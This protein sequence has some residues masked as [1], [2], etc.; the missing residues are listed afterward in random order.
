MSSSLIAINCKILSL[1]TKK[2]NTKIY[3]I[4]VYIDLSFWFVLFPGY[5][6]IVLVLVTILVYFENRQDNDE[7]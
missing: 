1:D 6:I 3:K 7:G 5:S 2:I 4:L